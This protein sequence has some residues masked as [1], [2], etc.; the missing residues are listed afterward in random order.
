MDRNR[1]E[2]VLALAC[3]DDLIAKTLCAFGCAGHSVSIK[4]VTL[5]RLR[6]KAEQTCS[7]ME[8]RR[9]LFCDIRLYA[10]RT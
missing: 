6:S 1:T 9:N 8:T 10:L 4:Y 7:R 3:A 5:S 2:H